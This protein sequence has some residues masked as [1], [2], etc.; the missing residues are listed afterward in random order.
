M[1]G[2]YDGQVTGGSTVGASF[3][4]SGVYADPNIQITVQVLD[5]PDSSSP[6]WVNLATTTSSATPSYYPDDSDPNNAYYTWAVD[7]TPVPSASFL[8]RWPQGGL[9]RTRAIATGGSSILD[10]HELFISDEDA[11][12]CFF[13]NSSANWAGIVVACG[14]DPA[15]GAAIASNN[16]TPADTFPNHTVPSY[17]G[18]LQYKGPGTLAAQQTETQAYYNKIAAPSTLSAFRQTY[19][20]NVAGAEVVTTYYN[21]GDLGIGREMHCATQGSQ[22]SCYVRNFAPPDGSG[23]VIFGD[24]S[25]LTLATSGG[26]PFATVAMHYIPPGTQDNAV[27]F[28]VYDSNGNL[29]SDKAVLDVRKANTDIPGNC[30]TCHG[31]NAHYDPVKHAVTGTAHFL[32]FDVFNAFKYDGGSFSYANQ[33][34]KFRK[35]NAM[36]AATN[37]GPGITE[38]LNGMYSGQ[39]NT[40][41][42]PAVSTF[43]PAAW[44]GNDAQKKLYTSVVAPY[45]RTCHLAMTDSNNGHLALDWTQYSDF[46]ALKSLIGIRVCGTKEMPNAEHT[47]RNFWDSPARAHLTGTLGLITS[48]NPQ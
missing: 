17:L 2:P 6:H 19:G 11:T 5:Q 21:D 34:E 45:C 31:G 40:P 37:A 12:D 24:L 14:K 43:I 29:K 48:C 25:S 16:P 8:Q 35:L 1:R 47:A 28:I 15:Y 3:Q 27:Q 26:T 44:S 36:V 39:L 32:P 30:L 22:V 33:A 7:A 18:F 41:N 9:L 20:F 42:Q 4:F 13:A 46:S 23:G 10:V 38:Y